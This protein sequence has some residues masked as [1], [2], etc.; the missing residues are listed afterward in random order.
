M[1]RYKL[2]LTALLAT[3]IFSAVFFGCQKDAKKTPALTSDAKG[4]SQSSNVYGALTLNCA[5]TPTQ[6]SLSLTVTAD[7]I[8]GAPAGF[9]IQW[10]TLDAF[11][12][13]ND[14]WPADASLYCAASFSG[15]PYGSKNTSQVG[16]STYNLGAGKSVT[17]YIGDL[18]TDELNSPLGYSTTVCNEGL[19][20]CGTQYVFRAFAHGGS[21]MNRSAYTIF[22]NA[23]ATTAPCEACG[24]NGGH[25]GFGYWKEHPELITNNITLG[26][27]SYSPT[28][29]LSILNQSP[30]GNGLVIL[31]HQLIAAKLNGLCSNL[32]GP[33]DAVFVGKIVP[34][35]GTD[36]VQPNTNAGLVSTLH[37]HNEDCLDCPAL[38]ITN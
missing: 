22:N 27:H 24:P 21:N 23:C 32:T 3:G 18:L 2:L 29:I 15:V 8:T 38:P 26:D 25:H 6:T 35:V 34:P 30:N 36:S 12:A 20:Q 11:D 7:A 19:L 4:G 16:G 31:A 9:T 5:G 13:N 14:Q 28:D 37:K 33:A 17:V 1:K 10:M